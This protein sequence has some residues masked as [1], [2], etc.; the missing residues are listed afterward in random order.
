MLI[1][2]QSASEIADEEFLSPLTV[3]TSIGFTCVSEM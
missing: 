1:A 3:S 2:V